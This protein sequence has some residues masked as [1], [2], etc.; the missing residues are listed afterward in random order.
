MIDDT[1]IES[2]KRGFGKERQ[3]YVIVPES[4]SDDL[5]RRADRGPLVQVVERF[6]D[7]NLV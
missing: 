2:K 7:H 1:I 3:R 6:K 5:P 4:Y